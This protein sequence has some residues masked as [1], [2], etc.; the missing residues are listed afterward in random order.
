M[1]NQNW[2]E[3]W[4]VSTGQIVRVGPK[5]PRDLDGGRLG[6]EVPA[7]RYTVTFTYRPRSFVV[8]AAV[9]GL[10]IPLLLALFVWRRRRARL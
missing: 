5:H 4:K 1:V 6:A 7:G 9:S 8:G 10:A 3:H 2:N